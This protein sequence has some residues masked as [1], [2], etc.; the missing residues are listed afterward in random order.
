MR[1][2]GGVRE[3]I[4]HYLVI[5]GNQQVATKWMSKS[6]SLNALF[7]SIKR[8]RKTESSCLGEQA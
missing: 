6:G 5:E 3:L 8:N 7:W 4:P 1:K 2:W